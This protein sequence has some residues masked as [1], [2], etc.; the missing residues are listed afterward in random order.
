[1]RNADSYFCIGSTHDVCQ[2]YAISSPDRLRAII[3]DG[4]S[5]APDT[6]FGSRLLVKAKERNFYE[7]DDSIILSARNSAD[8]IGLHDITLTAT[9][10]SQDCAPRGAHIERRDSQKSWP[11]NTGDRGGSPASF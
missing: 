11:H 2:D 7:N 1:M 8:A 5:S 4:C 3:S 10:L 9:L 6:D